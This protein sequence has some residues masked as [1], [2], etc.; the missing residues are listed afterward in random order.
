VQKTAEFVLIILSKLCLNMAAELFSPKLFLF[1]IFRVMHA[2]AA[3]RQ[4]CLAILFKSSYRFSIAFDTQLEY[5]FFHFIL[6]SYNDKPIKRSYLLIVL[7]CYEA[8][9]FRSGCQNILRSGRYFQYSF[10]I[11]K[12]FKN[13]ILVIIF[14]AALDLSCSKPYNF[15][16]YH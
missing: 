2:I 9:F 5:Q 4:H 8:D 16:K 15:C 6:Q 11:R 3:S 14:T 7:T 12:K 13:T 10:I 1:C